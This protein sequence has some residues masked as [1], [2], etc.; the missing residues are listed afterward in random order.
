MDMHAWV[1]QRYP[2]P[3]ALAGPVRMNG[4]YGQSNARCQKGVSNQFAGLCHWQEGYPAC[5][6]SMLSN[7]HQHA[8]AAATD[9]EEQKS[10]RFDDVCVQCGKNGPV[11]SCE[12]CEK[13]GF[14]IGVIHVVYSP[15]QKCHS[16]G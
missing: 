16:V 9:A 10:A 11:K 1:A 2:D 7:D 5:Q 15:L 4:A 8:A 13:F 12:A 3:A 14:D 6:L